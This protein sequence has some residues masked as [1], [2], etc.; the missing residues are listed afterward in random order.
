M[1]YG[2]NQ[3]GI[4]L[5][6]VL[7]ATALVAILAVGM[8]FAQHI[9]IRRT[10]N[11]IDGDKAMILALGLE[12]WAAQIMKRDSEEGSSDNLGEDWAMGLMP[13]TAG[14]GIISG[15]IVDLQGKI[16][17]N[18]LDGDDANIAEETRLELL[19]LFESCE[20]EDSNGLV[21]ALADWLDKDGEVRE[22]GS[23]DN[24]YLLNDPP[25]L[26]ANRLMVSPTELLLVRGMV[27][28]KYA[29]I[30]PSI[31]TLPVT[32]SININT[33]GARVVA[34]LSENITIAAAEEIVRD[35]PGSGYETVTDFLSHTSMAGSG[36][37]SDGL[38][39]ASNYFLLQGRANY[40]EAEIRL[41]SIF[42][43]K[44]GS[45]D[46]VARSIGTY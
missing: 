20:V 44:S 6:T 43:R 32:T 8:T 40:G 30:E 26:P 17:L 39:L 4:A 21:Q 28:E 34:S 24:D 45:L 15:S 18:N 7:L 33:A 3:R 9:D 22:E 35:R 11:L 29:C 23:E 46:L 19:N 25:Y 14:D 16:N 31:A 36:V 10:S 5:L 41:Y 37:D 27:P 42:F 13:I 2:K 1:I 12:E 38:T